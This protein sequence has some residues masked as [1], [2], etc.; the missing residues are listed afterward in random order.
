MQKLSLTKTVE[1]SDPATA[2]D[3]LATCTSLSKSR[4]KDA[5]TKGAVWL[6]RQ[7]GKQQRLRRATADLKPGDI[8]SIY[9]DEALLSIVPPR[10]ELISDQKR[11]S[12]W[13]K[14]AGLMSQ[15]TK[16][17]DHYSLLRQVEL[18][19]KPKRDAIPHSAP[20]P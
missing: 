11:Y 5:M 9:Y 1:P 19:Y 6:K 3:F 13:F 14:P 10:A 4:V 2:C 20:G 7:K 8:L 15:G 17:G 18:F 16:Y 12:V